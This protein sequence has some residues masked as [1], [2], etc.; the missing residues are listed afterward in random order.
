MINP[1]DTVRALAWLIADSDPQVADDAA[2]R[3]TSG[4]FNARPGMPT[5]FTHLK[6]PDPIIR[7]RAA[8]VLGQLAP[9]SKWWG[10]SVVEATRDTDAGVR[11]AAAEALGLLRAPWEE[12]NI[13]LEDLLDDP[14]AVVRA[15]AARALTLRQQ[16]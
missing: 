11:A 9:S 10:R 7:A 2:E 8:R 16:E 13:A 3:L 14:D 4:G 5:I 15:A 6:N 1:I 12:G